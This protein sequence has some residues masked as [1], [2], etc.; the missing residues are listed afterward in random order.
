MGAPLTHN[1]ED[2][3]FFAIGPLSMIVSG[4][5]Y[6]VLPDI[7]QQFKTPRKNRVAVDIESYPAGLKNF[8]CLMFAYSV[9]GEPVQVINLAAGESIPKDIIQQIKKDWL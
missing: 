4:V 3:I 2:L 6:K 5:L 1:M 8:E 7:I 9:D